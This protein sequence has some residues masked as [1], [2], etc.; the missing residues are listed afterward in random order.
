MVDA[1]VM[2]KWDEDDDEFHIK[3]L[4]VV[5]LMW[6]LPVTLKIFLFL[7]RMPSL[8]PLLVMTQQVSLDQ[9]EMVAVVMMALIFDY[10]QS[11]ADVM[12]VVMMVIARQLSH[13]VLHNVKLL[14]LLL[15]MNDDLMFPVK[16]SRC[17]VMMEMEQALVMSRP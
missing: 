1:L 8:A 6:Q 11:N 7:I 2:L 17:R 4:N 10:D 3:Q 15:V 13:V 14:S 12:I 9:I 16:R 5:L